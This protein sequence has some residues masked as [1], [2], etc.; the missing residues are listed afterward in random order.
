MPY[1]PF[2][3]TLHSQLRLFP[4]LLLWGRS[5]NHARE[6]V[7]SGAWLRVA[8]LRYAVWRDVLFGALT[9]QLP[10]PFGQ[11]DLGPVRLQRHIDQE[12]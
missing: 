4:R 9:P 6:G 7:P 5:K 2:C 1:A 3:H 11:L 12:G 8:P 10:P